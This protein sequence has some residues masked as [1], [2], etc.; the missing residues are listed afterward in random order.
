MKEKFGVL[1]EERNDWMWKQ[2]SKCLVLPMV[3]RRVCPKS[4]FSQSNHRCLPIKSPLKNQA[5]IFKYTDLYTLE[6]SRWPFPWMTASNIWHWYK[7]ER[8]KEMVSVLEFHDLRKLSLTFTAS[9]TYCTLTFLC[10]PPITSKVG[11]QRA[12]L[13]I[14]EL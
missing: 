11:S 9:L 14:V 5:S 6:I 4:P 1:L 3:Y 7:L 12:S 10:I 13:F 2:I 8:D